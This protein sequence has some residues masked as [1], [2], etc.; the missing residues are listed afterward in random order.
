MNTFF[1]I[2]NNFPRDYAKGFL[3]NMTLFTIVYLIFWK[4]LKNKIKN[5][6]IQFNQRADARQIKQ[7]IINAIFASVAGGAISCIVYYLSTKGCT[8]VYK[9][10]DDYPTFFAY[11][12]FFVLLIVDDTWFYW[13][14]RLM[15]HQKIYKYVHVVH[16]KSIDVTPYTSLSFHPVE[17]IISTF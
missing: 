9:D 14:H 11:A 2:F 3:M 12:G 13:T 6:R 5:L 15:H 1:E 4:L 7:E 10:I 17:S 8:K 16:H